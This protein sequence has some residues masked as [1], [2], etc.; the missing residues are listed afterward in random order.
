MWNG[1]VFERE[2]YINRS[3][4]N[5]RVDCGELTGQIDVWVLILHALW[6]DR[7]RSR[8]RTSRF[9]RIA[10]ADRNSFQFRATGR[11]PSVR[12]AAISMRT[13]ETEK[14]GDECLTTYERGWER[15]LNRSRFNGARFMALSTGTR[16]MVF[17]RWTMRTERDVYLPQ[18][19]FRLARIP[20]NCFVK[21][22]PRSNYRR[23]YRFN[24]VW[25]AN[26]RGR[27]RVHQNAF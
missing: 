27:A 13:F 22:L 6:I 25:P 14:C 10:S 5:A 7:F 19:Y 21:Y 8:D 15:W 17:R 23:A 24:K 2:P 18:R 3:R 12:S 26:L 4:C 1:I 9:V 11:D 16:S 20:W